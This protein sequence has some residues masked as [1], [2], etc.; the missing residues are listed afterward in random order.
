V[1]FGIDHFVKIDTLRGKIGHSD[2]FVNMRLY[3]GA[4]TN[5]RKK[6]NFL[7][8][9][10]HYLDVDELTNYHLTESQATATASATQPAPSDTA[11]GAAAIR[12][13]SSSSHEDGFNIF[14]VPFIDFKAALNIEK[15]KYH[16][17]WPKNFFTNIRMLA[18]QQLY[19]DTFGVDLAGGKINAR[20]HFNGADPKKIYLR[21]R[22]R[23]QDVNIEKMML[24]LD[25]FGQD[26]VINKNIKGTFN[27]Q[28]KSYV[29]VHP[30]LTPQIDQSTAE[31][32]VD[33]RNGAL[34]NFAPM[35]AM[36]SYFKDKNLNMV[37]FDTLR[38]VLT[39]KNGALSIPNMNI[40]SSLGFMEI[41]G[42][43]SMDM[44]MEY[45]IRIP[46]KLVTS[47]GFSKLFGKKPEEVDPSQVDAIE[48]RDMD[49]RVRFINLKISGTPSDYKVKLGK[50]K[51]PRLALA[52][53]P[54]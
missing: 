8:F 47:A 5:R 44:Q 46:L 15:I 48:Y 51:N 20:A 45:Y 14:Q 23:V 3:T 50:A 24:K 11:A 21:S 9:T 4:D 19:L 27:G 18:N 6:E 37:R 35:Q 40:N 32:D 16:H 7:Q 42:T 13:S 33:I 12:T 39:F 49:K 22:I 29:L 30:D 41:S 34:M 26:Y 17:L 52:D 54:K 1:K 28:I 10:S 36:A 43:Q 25:Y 38:N 53:A 31:L 2:F